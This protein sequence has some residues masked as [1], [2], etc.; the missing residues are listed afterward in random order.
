[1]L[2]SAWQFLL[3]L[4]GRVSEQHVRDYFCSLLFLCLWFSG[5]VCVVCMT[6]LHFVVFVVV[7]GG[8]GFYFDLWL[9]IAC[10]KACA[11]IMP[12][13]YR[14]ACV[15]WPL[16]AACFMWIVCV[17]LLNFCSALC[18]TCSVWRTLLLTSVSFV[19]GAAA[20]H[21]CWQNFSRMSVLPSV[22][23]LY[24]LAC[25]PKTKNKNSCLLIKNNNNSATKTLLPVDKTVPVSFLL[26]DRQACAVTWKMRARVT[27]VMP[28]PA[29]RHRPLT[30][31]LFARVGKAGAELTAPLTSMNVK[32][33]S[34]LSYSFFILECQDVRWMSGKWVTCPTVSLSLNVK[35]VCKLA[36]LLV[37]LECKGVQWMSRKW[38]TWTTLCLFLNVKKVCN[39]CQQSEWPILLFVY[40]WMSRCASLPY[41]W[42]SSNVKVCNECQQSE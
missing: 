23:K 27:P 40:P 37:I 32:K 5:I 19:D 28:T 39:E 2:Q 15:T 25:W 3:H 29:V 33:V 4:N 17:T 8:G 13:L 12:S 35:K 26:G 30:A 11:K 20:C 36:L 24:S 7:G 1:M 41:F 42:L 22:G 38:V 14:C 6:M 18:M 16:I 10:L 21:A 34:N 9:A 31:T